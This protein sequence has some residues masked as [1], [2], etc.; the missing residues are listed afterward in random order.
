MEFLYKFVDLMERKQVDSL[1]YTTRYIIIYFYYLVVGVMRSMMLRWV[2]PVTR[3]EK[4][5]D[6]NKILN[7]AHRMTAITPKFIYRKNIKKTLVLERR[8]EKGCQSV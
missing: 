2:A 7:V 1:Y 4:P 5:K 6:T 3:N 8:S